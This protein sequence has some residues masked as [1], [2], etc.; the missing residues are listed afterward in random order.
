MTLTF[1]EYQEL[2][3]DTRIYPDEVKILYPALGLGGEAGEVQEIVKKWLRDE[4]GTEM[5]Q[6]RC[7]KLFGEISD[8]L[9][10]IAALADDLGFK[11]GDIAQFNID[12]LQSR[13]E[14]GVLSGSG[15]DR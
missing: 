9:W 2:S 10:Y 5:S 3:A 6:E 4:P 12:K 7:E 11:L 8:T 13:K 1:D 15:S 14:R